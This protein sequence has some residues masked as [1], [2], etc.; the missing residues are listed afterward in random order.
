MLDEG[1]KWPL[2]IRDVAEVFDGA[3][4]DKAKIR[5]VEIQLIVGG[6]DTEAHAGPE[7]W[8]WLADVKGKAR[9]ES[10]QSDIGAAPDK[11]I[12]TVGGRVSAINRLRL[13]WEK[14]GIQSQL[15][16]VEGVKHES[17]RSISTVL[18]FLRPLL[19]DRVL[20]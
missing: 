14:N 4:I 10:G 5:E 7:F 18:D 12:E 9:K 11:P 16:I 3:T 1:L 15:N 8:K 19:A 6:G 2:G 17:N 20:D 13:S